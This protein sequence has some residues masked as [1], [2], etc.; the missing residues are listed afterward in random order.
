MPPE[1]LMKEQ[2]RMVLEAG[3]YDAAAAMAG[4]LAAWV[5][6]KGQHTF[7][8]LTD[9]QAQAVLA[10]KAIDEEELEAA[11]ATAEQDFQ[12]SIA[13]AKARSRIVP[14]GVEHWEISA[15]NIQALGTQQGVGDG[16]AP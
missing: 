9:E 10:Q 1:E 13:F 11:S 12:D 2:I 7:A 15:A 6:A 14:T 16:E 5:R 8:M 4:A 3:D